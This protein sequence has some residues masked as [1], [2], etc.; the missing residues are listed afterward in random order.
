MPELV[1]GPGPGLER[2]RRP[3]GVGLLVLVIAGGAVIATRLELSPILTALMQQGPPSRVAGWTLLLLYAAVLAMPFVPGAEIGLA[4]M[5]VF[6]AAMAWPVYIA[7]LLAL[8]ISFAAGRIAAR[9]RRP[10]RYSDA[11]PTI[12]GLAKLLQ[13]PWAQRL[14]RPLQRFRWVAL[15]VAFN[16]PGNVVIGGGGG[17]A[18]AIGFSRTFSYPAFLCCTTVAAAPVPALILIAEAMGFGGLLDNWIEDLVFASA[19]ITSAR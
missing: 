8:S 9:Y 19:S 4:L 6:G 13:R 2:R 16:M 15:V 7:T 1:D 14:L 5:A 10:L 11:D 18:M 17:I 3:W 12:D